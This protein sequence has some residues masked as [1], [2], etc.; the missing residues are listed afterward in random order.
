MDTYQPYTY[1][2]GWSR[3]DQWYYGARYAQ[4]CHPSDLWTTYFTSSKTVA[5]F[6]EL[7]GE[8]D[9]IRVDRL[10]QVAGNHL[11]RGAGIVAQA[12]RVERHQVRR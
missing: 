12:D 11:Q 4:N 9:I 7:Y 2:I 5:S 6:R 10:H 8:P 1:M 3:L